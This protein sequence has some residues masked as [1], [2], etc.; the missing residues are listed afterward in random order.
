MTRRSKHRIWI[1]LLACA[2]PAVWPASGIAQSLYG[3][4]PP[5][6][7]SSSPPS[8]AAPTPARPQRETPRDQRSLHPASFDDIVGDNHRETRLLQLSE[9]P[10]IHVLDYENLRVQ[11]LAMNR[12]AAF[13]EWQEAPKDRVLNDDALAALIGRAA[14]H[15]DTLYFGHDYRASDLARFFNASVRL[16][17]VLN[18][19]EKALQ[20]M[21]IR[22]GLIRRNRS[23]MTAVPPERVL[24]SITK[25]QEDDPQ[26]ARN[27]A[28]TKHMRRIILS[29]ELSHGEFFTHAE[30]ARY[31]E[32]FWRLRLS[33]PQRAAFIH[34]L[35]T[36]Q[37]Y[38]RGNEHLL[39]NEFQAY[40]AYSG[41]DGLFFGYDVVE[42]ID[43]SEMACL[44]QRFL[45][46]SPARFK[47]ATEARDAISLHDCPP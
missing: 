8:P 28:V 45:A 14:E 2:I 27:E 36:A 32:D 17:V 24:I 42:G 1:T 38:D 15:P 13:I 33:A 25:E 46:G 16:G 44:R 9:N 10:L 3:R 26:T 5:A 7:G 20:N 4:S 29:H 11:G 6:T 30:Y 18:E 43:K 12:I 34:F 31:C 19:H 21:L 47:P 37:H 40:I 22:H 35:A 39:I 41:T 23:Q